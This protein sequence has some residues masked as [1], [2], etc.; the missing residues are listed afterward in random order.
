MTI[1]F[2][3]LSLSKSRNLIL[4]HWKFI[5]C[6][7]IHWLSNSS[8]SLWIYSLF[9]SYSIIFEAGIT[10]HD[11]KQIFLIYKLLPLKFIKEK[12]LKLLKWEDK[13][14][15]DIPFDVIKRG[16]LLVLVIQLSF[17]CLTFVFELIA[18]FY[19]N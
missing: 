11:Y 14:Y 10:Q 3:H 9:C 2:I 19:L 5:N 7:L 17:A 1:W 12:V 13:K 4:M 18:Y 16:P 8:Y 15:N 6:E